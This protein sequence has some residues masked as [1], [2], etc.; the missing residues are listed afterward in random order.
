[1]ET[2]VNLSISESTTLRKVTINKMN[3]PKM[4]ISKDNANVLIFFF[5]SR[6]DCKLLFL[7]FCIALKANNAIAFWGILLVVLQRWPHRSV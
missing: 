3:K 4:Q 1:M 7:K 5:K 6:I 2:F